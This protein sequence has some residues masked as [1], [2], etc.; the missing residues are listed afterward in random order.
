MDFLDMTGDLSEFKEVIHKA[1]HQ[2]AVK[3]V[4]KRLQNAEKVFLK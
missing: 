3:T 1:G 4:V 2:L